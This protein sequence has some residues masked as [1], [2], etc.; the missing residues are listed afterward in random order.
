MCRNEYEPNVLREAFH[1]VHPIRENSES[2]LLHPHRSFRFLLDVLR[3]STPPDRTS[4]LKPLRHTEWLATPCAHLPHC[5]S[6]QSQLDERRD[7]ALANPLYGEHHPNR[8]ILQRSQGCRARLPQ[9]ALEAVAVDRL[10]HGSPTLR[11]MLQRVC[12]FGFS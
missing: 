11:T 9:F 6:I 10:A 4:S 2:F 5:A 8:R 1:P 3:T 7:L 12:G